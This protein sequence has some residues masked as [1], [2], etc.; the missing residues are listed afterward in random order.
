MKSKAE[1]E[2]RISLAISAE[3]SAVSDGISSQAIGHRLEQVSQ[4]R[5]RDRRARHRGPFRACCHISEW[6]QRQ[7]VV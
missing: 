1:W 7:E 3:N 5:L 6:A 4:A 2:I